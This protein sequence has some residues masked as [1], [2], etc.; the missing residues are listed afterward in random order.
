M[1]SMSKAHTKAEDETALNLNAKSEPRVDLEDELRPA[2]DAST[3]KISVR[4]KYVED[5][6]LE[7][8]AEQNI[9]AILDI[10]PDVS[11]KSDKKATSTKAAQL[12]KQEDKRFQIPTP[13]QRKNLSVEFA[14][15]GKVIYGQ[16][17]DIVRVDGDYSLDEIRSI[18]KGIKEKKITLYEIKATNRT[19][20]TDEFGDY[21][22]SLSTAEVL[23]AQSLKDAYMFVFVNINTHKY[24]ELTLP[25]VYA[26]AQAIYP[27]WSI[28]FKK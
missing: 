15:L 26:K 7:D 17:F 24:I 1:N 13:K 8:L 6:G 2:S 28:R 25:A 19:N 20:V 23:V 4:G 3:L 27:S 5:D 9:E 11:S 10:E 16:A 14:K 12:L 22:F 21:F 18:S